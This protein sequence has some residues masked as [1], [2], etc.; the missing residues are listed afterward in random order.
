[1]FSLCDK[2]MSHLNNIHF[3]K[4]SLFL[5]TL[6]LASHGYENSIY[7]EIKLFATHYAV[8]NVCREEMCFRKSNV[9]I[10]QNVTWMS[11]DSWLFIMSAQQFYICNIVFDYKV[12]IDINF[13]FTQT[14]KKKKKQMEFFCIGA[15]S[16]CQK[17]KWNCLIS[18]ILELLANHDFDQNKAVSE[19]CEW[20]K[21][22]IWSC[23][24]FLHFLFSTS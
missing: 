24:W 9:K 17:M 6:Y 14:K 19:D 21:R 23:W 7:T 1:M 22:N 11:Y 5:C 15:I 16:S 8:F 12:P 4:C 13:T 20:M 10:R 3:Q 2:L 18:F